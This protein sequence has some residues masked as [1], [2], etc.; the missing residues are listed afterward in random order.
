[1]QLMETHG[2]I[3]SLCSVSFIQLVT[4][5][6]LAD[7]AGST[8]LHTLL[9]LPTHAA[10]CTY[11]PVEWID[12]VSSSQLDVRGEDDPRP[13]PVGGRGGLLESVEV[14]GCSLPHRYL[15]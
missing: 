12:R 5:G 8:A 13:A 1:M 7:T 6:Q 9:L 15:S 10:T 2:L 14:A 4:L 11:F 3:H